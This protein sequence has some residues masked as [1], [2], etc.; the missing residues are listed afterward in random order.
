MTLQNIN[1]EILQTA[2]EADT[3][4]WLPRGYTGH[5]HLLELD[6]FPLLGELKGA[7]NA[8]L[9]DPTLAR[10]LSPDNVPPLRELKGACDPT[11]TQSY[12]SSPLL[13]GGWVGLYVINNPLKYTDSIGNDWWSALLQGVNVVVGSIKFIPTIVAGVMLSVFAVGSITASMSGAFGAVDGGLQAHNALNNSV[14][15][16]QLITISTTL[17]SNTYKHTMI[18]QSHSGG[19]SGYAG[20]RPIFGVNPNPVSEV[21]GSIYTRFR[22]EKG[23]D[24]TYRPMMGSEANPVA[25]GM[26]SR[27]D[28]FVAQKVSIYDNNDGSFN[29]GI[30]NTFISSTSRGRKVGI[31]TSA[32]SIGKGLGASNSITATYVYRLRTVGGS[33]EF[34]LISQDIR[35]AERFSVFDDFKFKGSILHD[36]TIPGHLTQFEVL[37]EVDSEEI[38]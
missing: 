3:W 33:A 22:I 21:L 32:V 27:I 8:R 29:L 6:I 35:G 36:N 24:G 37:S 17:V 14:A 1:Q 4:K 23:R 15:V 28:A 30:S 18:G 16:S 38:H 10:M 31:G 19:L 9:Y 34:E 25:R 2:A 7:M 13:C 5:E 26:D 20:T 11:N 12:N